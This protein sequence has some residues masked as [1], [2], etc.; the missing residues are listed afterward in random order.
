M[1]QKIDNRLKECNVEG[2]YVG[3]NQTKNYYITM[4]Q[5]SERKFVVTH[6]VNIKP[7]AYFT[8]REVELQDLR[9]WVE[10][11][12]KSVLVSGMGGIGKTQICRKLFEEY[13]KNE[14]GL[15]SHIGYIQYD[16]DMNTSLQRCLKYKEQERQEDNLEAA[17]RELEYLASDG[18]LLL[19]VD[20]VNASITSDPGLE[21]LKYIPGAII[22]TSRRTSFS[23][24]FEPYRI[25]FLN[26]EQ[27]RKIYEKIR[28]ENSNKGVEEEEVPDL[29]YIINILAA[30][31]TITVEFL[32][33]LAQ[34]K[35]WTVRILREK[36]ESN[37]F[38]L[39]Y[40]DEEEKLINIQKA[41]ETLYDLSELTE[42]EQNI[43][44]AFS[45]FPYIPLAVETCNE[46]LLADAGAS[47]DDD[48]LMGLYRKGWLQYDMAQE[49]YALHPVFAQFIYERFKPKEEKHSG[50]IEKCQKNLNLGLLEDVSALECYQY[51][52]LAENIINKLF[53]RKGM[54]QIW[55]ITEFAILLDYMAK[56]KEAEKWFKISLKFYIDEFGQ[57]HPNTVAIYNNL[58]NIYYRRKDYKEAKELHEKVKKIREK[59]LRENLL[60]TAISYVNLAHIYNDQGE[61]DK[62]LGLYEKSLRIHEKVLGVNH[63]KTASSYNDLAQVYYGMGEYEKAKSLFEKGLRIREKVL[64][65]NRSDTAISYNDLAGIYYAYGEY[66]KAEDLY[67]KALKI[68]KETLGA[69]HLQTATS[70]HNLAVVYYVQREYKKAA[71]L[72]ERSLEI[73]EKVLGEDFLD[74]EANK[75]YNN[76]V[77]ICIVQEEYKKAESL[78]TKAL[79]IKKKVLGENHLDTA[80]S[81]NNLGFVYEEEGEYEKA[82]GCVLKAYKILLT[83]NDPGAKTVYNN[84]EFTYS[85][86]HPDGNFEQWLE[87]KMEK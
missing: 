82:L 14:H 38:Q 52:L 65:V 76:L 11:G 36:L 57:D 29:E 53:N 71:Y 81:F 86:L 37:G 12:R 84:L 61:Y 68:Y 35:H 80:A 85:E 26:T 72:Y 25:G 8:G 32:A 3:G 33:C 47:E 67:I 22:L 20:N 9:Q 5:E 73:K 16:S 39:E 4:F 78:C 50:L 70:Y 56:Y 79:R 17:W 42:A 31:H 69:E 41:Y 83:L 44:E 34:T 55:F 43:L 45:V 7:V 6:K 64:G 10:E 2:D 66:K 19:F 75:A 18:K 24:E 54:D 23:K 28:F 13:S 21:R 62:A 49:S 1:D 46:W 30:K 60:D 59:V 74:E 27:C 77:E 58:A 51:I 40:K 48:I 87:E 15:F 63:P